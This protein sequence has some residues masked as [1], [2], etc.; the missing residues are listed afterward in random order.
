MSRPLKHICMATDI[1]FWHGST[2]A[3]QRM[4]ALV[5]YLSHPPFQLSVFYLGQFQAPELER[6][7]RLPCEVVFFESEKPPES[8]LKRIRWY[9]EATRNQL[10]KWLKR[11]NSESANVGQPDP[12]KLA[13]YRWPWAID[14]FRSHVARVR[15]RAIICQYVTMAY[16]LDALSM[17]ER[18]HTLC[19]LDTHDILHD[20]GMQF[21]SA[22]YLHWLEIS[23]A[24]EVEVWNRFDAV[25]AIQPQEAER[26]RAAV[27]HPRVIVAGHALRR[28]L[29]L[30]S[31]QKANETGLREITIGYI[32]SANYS[33]WHAIN[34]FLIEVWPDLL[35]LQDVQVELLIAGKICDWFNLVEGRADSLLKSR[36]R[37]QGPV[38]RLEEFYSQI[39]L[40]INPVQFGTGLKIKNVEA[41]AFG[42]PLVST[43]SGA[44]GMSPKVLEAC[45]VAEDYGQMSTQLREICRSAPQLEELTIAAEEVAKSEFSPQKVFA[46]LSALLA[47]LD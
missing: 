47:N 43:A 22:G 14:Q 31:R 1:P 45:L 4:L 32:G 17:T 24:E 11:S 28:P 44:A 36:V 9:A 13:D 7:E 16:L 41:V 12:L 26:I 33:N 10:E 30:A 27:S 39:E 5:D 23:E 20:R 42:K 21:H 34:R 38:E 2:G 37:L 29:R 19:V 46:E 3:E 18:R 40:A 8:F 25:I 15:P 6:I 35:E